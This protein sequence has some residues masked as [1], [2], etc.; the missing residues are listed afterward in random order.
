MTN[1][2]LKS[3]ALMICM[4]CLLVTAFC[5]ATGIYD[6]VRIANP[7]FTLCSY[8]FQY[9]QTNEQFARRTF[10]EEEAKPNDDEITRLRE[11][12]YQAAIRSERR[13]GQHCLIRAVIAV[14]I[15]SIIL[16]IHILIFKKVNRAMRIHN[17]RLEDIGSNAPN[18]Q[19]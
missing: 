19:P 13:D 6:I 2:M 17:E 12:S 5:T 16:L 10:R 9:H 18:P 11:E 4:A 14:I 15:S 1:F 7:E 8:E 3:Y